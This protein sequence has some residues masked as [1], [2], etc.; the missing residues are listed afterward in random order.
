MTNLEALLATSYGLRFEGFVTAE[1]VLEQRRE[2]AVNMERNRLPDPP[3]EGA[4]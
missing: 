3:K 4:K 1:F 2:V